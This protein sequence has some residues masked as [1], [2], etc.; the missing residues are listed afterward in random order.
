M[1]DGKVVGYHR[2]WTVML[3]GEPIGPQFATKAEAT[4]HLNRSF[5]YI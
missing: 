4:Y 3:D 1:I 5:P 2:F